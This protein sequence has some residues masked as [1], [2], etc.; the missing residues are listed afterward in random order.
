MNW[1][2]LVL[3]VPL[4]QL[5]WRWR[6]I[7]SVEPQTLFWNTRARD[8]RIYRRLMRSLQMQTHSLEYRIPLWTHIHPVH[9]WG[10]SNCCSSTETNQFP[11]RQNL[12]TMVRKWCRMIGSVFTSLPFGKLPYQSALRILQ[13][14][15]SKEIQCQLLP[16]SHQSLY[17]FEIL[18]PSWVIL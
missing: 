8:T 4:T 13:T 14:N 5:W 9:S 12:T 1:S 6:Q 2:L 17:L 16:S 18:H 10:E 11:W 7:G 3:V 15:K